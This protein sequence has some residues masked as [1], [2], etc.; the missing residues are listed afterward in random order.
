MN[1]LKIIL[2]YLKNLKQLIN[3]FKNLLEYIYLDL[4][5]QTIIFIVV[6]KVFKM[7]KAFWKHLSRISFIFIYLQHIV[8]D[9]QHLD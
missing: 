5:S 8:F 9:K 7:S 3:H 2:V 1:F 6:I 4:K